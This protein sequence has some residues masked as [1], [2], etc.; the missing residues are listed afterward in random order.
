MK[1]PAFL[2]VALFTLM[3][4][5]ATAA[6]PKVVT[7]SPNFWAVG[8]D[9]LRQKTVSLTF[10]QAMRS[11]FWDWFGRDVLTPNSSL[12]TVVSPDRMTFTI[13]V[14]LEHG[15][16]YICALNER[17][18]S[19]IGFQNEKGLSLP[20]TFLVFQ[21]AGTPTPDDAPPVLLRTIPEN[22]AHAVDSS[23]M[24]SITLMFDR[25]MNIKKHGL[26]L[27]E[28]ENP[29]D[30]SRSQ[31]GYS[32]DGRTFTLSYQFKP[33]MQYRLELNSTRDIGFASAKRVP[34]WPAQVLFT[35]ASGR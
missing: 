16:V 31:F 7:S 1:R 32:A 12:R 6:P 8:V 26:R 25:P 3:L 29:I 2:C 4:A 18:I 20:P 23:K 24:N 33:A 13:D 30:L 22:G 9:A 19:G 14:Q 10:D 35:T 5:I 28:N 15:K 27:T 17:G 34:M 11:A 21:T